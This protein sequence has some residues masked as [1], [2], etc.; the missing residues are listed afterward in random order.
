MKVQ[1]NDTYD[2]LYCCECKNRIHLG[3]K[4]ISVKE[5][6]QGEQY[7]KHFHPECLPETE[8]EE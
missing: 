5:S 8:D 4:F 1:Y 7:Y 3:E 6:Y 2:E